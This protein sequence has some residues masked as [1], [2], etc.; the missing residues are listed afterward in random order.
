MSNRLTER[1]QKNSPRVGEMLGMGLGR[2]SHPYLF[3]RCRAAVQGELRSPGSSISSPTPSR[4]RIRPEFGHLRLDCRSQPGRPG[5]EGLSQKTVGFSTN[6]Q[7]CRLVLP[8]SAIYGGRG[9][10]GVTFRTASLTLDLAETAVL[11]GLMSSGLMSGGPGS[12]THVRS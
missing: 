8:A 10:P 6:P 7:L 11:C 1:V 12:E 4:L 9:G 2:E 3:P 5:K